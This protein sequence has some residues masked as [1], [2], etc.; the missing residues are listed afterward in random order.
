[1]KERKNGR[2]GAVIQKIVSKLDIL[3]IIESV[4]CVQLRVIAW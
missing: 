3:E 2:S 1:M 4:G